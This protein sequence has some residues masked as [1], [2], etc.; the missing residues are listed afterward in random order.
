[1]TNLDDLDRGLI[2]ALHLDARA[3]FTRVAEVLGTSTQTVVRRYRRLRATAALRVVGL[4]DPHRARR[5]QWIVR[6]TATPRAAHDT[7]RA[8]AARPDTS[9]VRLTSGGTEIVAII[10]TDPPGTTPD[11]HALLLRDIPRTASITA[12]SAHHLLHTYLGG[13]TAWRGHLTALTPTQQAL[14]QPPAPDQPPNPADGP[15]GAALAAGQPAP[16]DLTEVDLRLL[17]ELARDGRA[18]Y[19]ELAVATGWSAST[20]ARRIDHLRATGVLYFD[21]E[22]DDT[23]LGVTTSTLLWM[24]VAPADLDR[25]ATT[26]ATHPEL[27]IVATTTGPTNLLATALCPDPESLHHYLTHRLARTPV[28]HLESAPVLHTLKAVAP[29][30]DR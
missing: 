9:W 24:S 29:V 26:L 3:P 14:L 2:H 25:V 1:M 20:V 11:P 16:A 21:V 6:L 4:A 7:A 15:A 19:T 27:A 13:P 8:L 23:L 22:I 30:A 12:V 18:S 5:P 28:T 17:A 10:R